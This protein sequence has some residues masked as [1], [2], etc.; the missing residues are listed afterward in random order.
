[1]IDVV[2]VIP[3]DRFI[4]Q[5]KIAKLLRLCRLPRLAKLFSMEKFKKVSKSLMTNQEDENI[6]MQQYIEYA[7]QIFRLIVYAIIATYFTGCFWFL[8]VTT[9]KDSY[10][11]TETK[12]LYFSSY[13]GI[14][15]D[16]VSMQVIKTCYFA[17]N[18][19]STVGYG[20]F[21]PVNQVEMSISFPIMLAG[22]AFFSYIMGHFIEIIS[23]Y[24]KKMGVIDKSGELYEWMYDLERFNTYVK[25]HTTQ[26]EG[27]FT[28]FW[29]NDR[30]GFYNESD[31][32][33]PGLPHKL[34][35]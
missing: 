2:A 10:D 22:V 19:L 16:N 5:G 20:D 13:F 27:H 25:Q 9:I 31:D 26:I 1:M 18:T 12:Q 33:L 30:L 34:K 4:P 3:F 32:Y 15:S 28:Y 8:I 17:L 14:D 7:Y 23:N 35:N 6:V 24:D 11:G 29:Q 21:S